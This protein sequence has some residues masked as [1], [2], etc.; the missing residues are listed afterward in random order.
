MSSSKNR[1]HQATIVREWKLFAYCQW[2]EAI[3]LLSGT[4]SCWTIVRDS[5]KLL[6]LVVRDWKLLNYCRGLEAVEVFTCYDEERSFYNTFQDA[7]LLLLQ[8]PLVLRACW[9]LE[10]GIMI[11]R[12]NVLCYIVHVFSFV[13][14][15]QPANCFTITVFDIKR[16]HKEAR[17]EIT[18]FLYQATASWLCLVFISFLFCSSHVQAWKN[19]QTKDRR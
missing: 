8:V 5:R 3:E 17:I 19:K 7:L 18:R 1:I 9:N 10:V 6:N 14:F 16:F 15:S 13:F 2:L 12:K 11:R 4:G